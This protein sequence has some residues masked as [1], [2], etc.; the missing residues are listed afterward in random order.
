MSG[1]V[2]RS[3]STPEYPRPLPASKAAWEVVGV[4]PTPPGT[5]APSPP[6][7]VPPA[8]FSALAPLL[9]PDR[10]LRLTVWLPWC[11]GDNECL[12]NGL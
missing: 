11:F 2:I 6:S 9:T 5:A 4:K 12:L 3:S 1:F 8:P 7:R 10:V